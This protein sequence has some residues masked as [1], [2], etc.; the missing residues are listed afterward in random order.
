MPQ[1][2]AK[3]LSDLQDRITTAQ[4]EVDENAGILK[5][6]MTQLKE[7]FDCSNA[8]E[9]KTLLKKLDKQHKELEAE[10]EKDLHDLWEEMPDE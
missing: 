10:I 4:R 1:S 2:I 9:A 7:E 6:H 8:T 3:Q 5:A